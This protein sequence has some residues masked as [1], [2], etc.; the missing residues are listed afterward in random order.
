MSTLNNCPS[1]HSTNI[2]GLKKYKSENLLSCNKCQL[3]FCSKIPSQE[4]LKNHYE[5]YG[6]NDFLSPITVKRYQE[7]LLEFQP[8]NQQNKILDIGCGLGFFLEEALIKN[9]KV[10]GTEF[11]DE[12]IDICSKKGIN[13]FKG[14][15]ENIDFGELKFD[16]ITSFEVLEH[17]Q[18]PND[19]IE[20]LYSLLRPGGILYLTTPNFNSLNR[21]I[22]K[23]NWNV[24]SYPEHLCYFNKKSLNYLFQSNNLKKLRIVTHGISPGRLIKSRQKEQMDFSSS[25]TTDE[26]LRNSI[27]ENKILG[28][29]KNLINWKLNLFGLG[30]TLKAWYVKS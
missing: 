20:I 25:K 23:K 13:M 6:R 18:N 27:E 7:L 5:H 11:T 17:L 19:H 8:Y 30:E 3:V 2:K 10:Y 29:I 15:L 1:C 16:V 26:S 21:R 12:A 24:I 22:L 4:E 28:L 14:S 9:W